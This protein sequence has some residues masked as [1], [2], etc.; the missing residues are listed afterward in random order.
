MASKVLFGPFLSHLVCAEGG[1]KMENAMHIRRPELSESARTQRPALRP[2]PDR[3]SDPDAISPGACV[4]HGHASVRQ[5]LPATSL[6]YQ[7]SQVTSSLS[8]SSKRSTASCPTA[9]ASCQARSR[10]PSGLRDWSSVLVFHSSN[11]HK[12]DTPKRMTKNDFM[13]EKPS[14][15]PRDYP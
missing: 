7:D 9:R 3:G 15:T 13:Y 10:H 1:A 11:L 14:P 5:P 4:A 6:T 8:T 2:S 12:K